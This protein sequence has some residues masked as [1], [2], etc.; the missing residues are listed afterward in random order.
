M[1]VAVVV[2]IST[3]LKPA[4]CKTWVKRAGPACAPYANPTSCAS[5]AGTQPVV[6]AQ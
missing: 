1:L 5:E 2:T 6:D 3:L 4:S